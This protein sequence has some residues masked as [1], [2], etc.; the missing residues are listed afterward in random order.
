MTSPKRP[1]CQV[2]GVQYLPVSCILAASKGLNDYLEFQ[3]EI[4]C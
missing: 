1:A 2:Y 4:E 3:A